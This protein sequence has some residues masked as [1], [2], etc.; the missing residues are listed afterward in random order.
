MDERDPNDVVE[1]GHVIEDDPMAA[2]DDSE[3]W[4]PPTDPVV[5]PDAQGDVRI[6]GGFAPSSMDDDPPVRRSETGGSPDE[7]IAD[8]IRRELREDAATAALSILV[9]VRR[10]VA[11]LRGQVPGPEDAENAEEVAS[12]VPGVREVV[13]ELDVASL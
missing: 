12:R 11:H 13:E 8:A 6:V 5:K 2:T 7:A 4:A 9:A 1:H 3:T 10:G